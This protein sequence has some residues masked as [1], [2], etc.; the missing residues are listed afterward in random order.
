MDGDAL[1]D[2]VQGPVRLTFREQQVLDYLASHAGRFVPS[3]E[4]REAV[5]GEYSSPTRPLEV[6]LR[7]RRKLGASVIESAPGFGYRVSNARACG[8]ARRCPRCGR[9]IVEYRSEGWVCFGCGAQ[10]E[11]AAIEVAE[12]EV[13]RAAYRGGSRQGEPWTEEERRFVLENDARMGLEEMGRQLD[14]TASAVRGLR[15]QLGLPRKA[16]VREVRDGRPRQSQSLTQ[17]A[18]QGRGG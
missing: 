9:G 17:P 10:G 16:Y 15:A 12:L 18:K 3:Q 4:L 2:R 5:F 1:V 13:G 6:V 8:L 14:R 7:I 11:R